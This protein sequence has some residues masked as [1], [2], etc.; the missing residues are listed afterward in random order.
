MLPKDHLTIAG[1]IFRLSQF[2][3]GCA[4]GIEWIEGQDAAN[5]PVIDRTVL[6]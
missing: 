1:D 4:I 5:H 6:T 3:E 2:A